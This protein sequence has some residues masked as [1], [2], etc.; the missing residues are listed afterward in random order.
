[1]IAIM[2]PDYRQHMLDASRRPPEVEMRRQRTEL[3]QKVEGRRFTALSMIFIGIILGVSN[4]YAVSGPELWQVAALAA[5][6]FVGGIAW[7]VMLNRQL[8]A[9]KLAPA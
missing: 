3:I 6:L 5:A 9:L 4:Y 2:G 8:A 7:S 1:M